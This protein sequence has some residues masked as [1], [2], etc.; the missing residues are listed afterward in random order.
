MNVG[1]WVTNGVDALK[2]VDTALLRNLGFGGVFVACYEDEVRW[3]VD[4]VA[5][6]VR[7]AKAD[8]LDPFAVPYG[9]GRFLD[10]D[11]LIESLYVQTHPDACQTDS[12][13]RRL[14][15]AC[16]NN[17][18][19][20]EWFS[21]SVRTL[22]WLLECTGFLWDQPGFHYA[23][24]Q[25]SCR[26]GYCARL[27]RAG[28]GHEMP[29]E[30]TDEV[31]QFRCNSVTMFTLAAAAA[32]ES[33][34]RRLTSLVM[35]SPHLSSGQHLTGNEDVQ[36]LASC[37]GVSGLCVMVPWQELGWDMEHALREAAEGPARV[38]H[39]CDGVC[40][41]GVNCSPRPE[42]RTIETIQFAA[43]L[44]IDAMVMADY[45]TLIESPA[46]PLIREPLAEALHAASS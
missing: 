23:R 22:A 37:A 31:I 40:A 20:L 12:R 7:R 33:V 43:R 29:R 5:S 15:K 4:D 11:P 18:Q 34:D 6:F 2:R 16:P 9:Y 10:P 8:G 17:P 42:D 24:G 30:L 36:R 38:T 13:G 46:F 27:F 21:S 41:V 19:F 28:Y 1:I 32:I 25:W 3:R 14:R 45:T 44:G 39:A 35:P 26:C